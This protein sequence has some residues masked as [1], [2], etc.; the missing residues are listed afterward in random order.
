MI[1]IHQTDSILFDM[2]GTLWDGVEPYAQGFNDFFK[3]RNIEK[4][5]T[6]DDLYGLMG[7]EEERYVNKTL[8]EFPADERKEMYRNIVDFQYK[9][10]KSKGGVLFPF[11]KVGLKILSQ[12]YKLFIVSNCA[13][14]MIKY[15][16]EWA[17]IGE[18]ITDSMAHGANLKSKSENIKNLI[19]QY[20]LHGAVYVGDTDSDSAQCELASIPF[21]FVSYGFGETDRYD[22]KF[23]S[24]AELTG[25]FDKK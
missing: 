8:S 20:S 14:F 25:Y 15:F 2:D 4:R 19:S 3:S 18:Y 9:Q 16:M 13:E 6:P 24:F 21:V 7:M 5:I 12:Q 22:I 10:I 1:D 23:D 17:G 11:V